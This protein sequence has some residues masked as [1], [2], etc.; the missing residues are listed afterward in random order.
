M[1]PVVVAVISALSSV[2]VALVGL[3]V[4]RKKGLPGINAEIEQRMQQLVD[5]LRADVEAK[6]GE[7]TGKVRELESCRSELAGMRSELR[8][9][10]RDLRDTQ[11]ELLSLYRSTGRR[12][13]DRL[14]EH[15]G[16]E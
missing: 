4:A 14:T 8:E 13:P 2:A 9:T 3:W 10:K 11:F 15:A 12:P 6:N 1:E 5:T 7:L 16:G